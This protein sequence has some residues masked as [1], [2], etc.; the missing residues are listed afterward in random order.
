MFNLYLNFNGNLLE[1]FDFYK[2]IFGGEYKI[3]KKYKDMPH[4]D[5]LCDEDKE[6]IMHL[7]LIIDKDTK[8]MGSDIL[9]V[10]GQEISIGNNFYINITPKSEREAFRI[11]GLLSQGGEV[12]MPLQKTFWGSLFGTVRDKYK[13]Q[14]MINIE[15]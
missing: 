1:A 12:Q 3:L 10:W 15:N 9:K 7:E 11:F 8:L 5:T 4:G 14:W 2:E 13:I 6:K